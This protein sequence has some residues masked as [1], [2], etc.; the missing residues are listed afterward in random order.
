MIVYLHP[1]QTPQMPPWLLRFQPDSPGV[2]VVSRQTKH[3]HMVGIGDPLVFD[4]PPMEAFA[5]VEDG[6]R[7]ALIGD[8]SPVHLWRREGWHGTFPATSIMGEIWQAP[9]ILSEEGA[10]A[11][12]VAFKGRDFLP[13]PTPEQARC[14]DI[15]RAAREAI[16]GAGID[17]GPACQWAAAL[18][19]AANA[20]SEATVAELGILDTRLVVEVL[21]VATSQPLKHEVPA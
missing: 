8:L 16:L 2:E 7:A 15:A 6:W 3:G 19:A 5:E 12:L 21:S 4:C 14:E 20:I 10:R 18:L 11:Y 17:M 9:K 13:S 1:S